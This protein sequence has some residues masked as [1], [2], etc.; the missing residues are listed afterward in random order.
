MNKAAFDDQRQISSSTNPQSPEVIGGYNQAIED[1]FEAIKE[2]P[3]K[4]GLQAADTIRDP[5]DVIVLVE[6]AQ[7]AAPTY[8]VDNKG[9]KSGDDIIMSFCKGNKD[10]ESVKR[11]EGFIT[12]TLLEVA[13]LQLTAVNKGDLANRETSS[14]IT[15][16]D[17]AL[18]W[19][20]KRSRDRK[21]RGVQGSYK[22]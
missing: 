5:T 3:G 22:K 19:L 17:E 21:K 2:N 14:A 18:S 15:K 9:L 7:Y 13:R 1:L 16:I 12:E 10:D 20:N 4:F 6:G 8:L 11:Q